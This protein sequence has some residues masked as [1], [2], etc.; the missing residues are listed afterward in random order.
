MGDIFDEDIEVIA[1][2][3]AELNQRSKRLTAQQ[4]LIR[5]AVEYIEAQDT[6]SR[7]DDSAIRRLAKARVA[8]EDAVRKWK[9]AQA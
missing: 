9:E 4:I 7:E 8:L 6:I 2:E 5:C 3:I 1:A